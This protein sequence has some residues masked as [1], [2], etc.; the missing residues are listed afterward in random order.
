MTE[1][2]RV[3]DKL[4]EK[5]TWALCFCPKMWSRKDE[6]LSLEFIIYEWT[7]MEGIK[8]LPMFKSF[9]RTYRIE[10]VTHWM[11]LPEKPKDYL[12]Y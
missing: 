5:N 7:D 6:I 1:W 12:G 2:I 11:P 10:E 4:P 8:Q 9:D 3:K